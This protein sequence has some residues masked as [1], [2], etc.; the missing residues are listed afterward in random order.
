MA[1]SCLCNPRLYMAACLQTTGLGTSCL[2][3]TCKDP[4]TYHS[5]WNIVLVCALTLHVL[6]DVAFD[7]F[8]VTHLWPL[9]SSQNST[10][11]IDEW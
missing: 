1:L 11:C 9:H 8:Y 5:M 10:I 7:C 2:G 3:T 4:N 6:S